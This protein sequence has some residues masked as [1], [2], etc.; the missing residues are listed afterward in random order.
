MVHEQNNSITSFSPLC[1][2]GG[3]MLS[4]QYPGAGQVLLLRD[5]IPL[6]LLV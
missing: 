5:E 1:D 6:L 2:C 4:K 3:E